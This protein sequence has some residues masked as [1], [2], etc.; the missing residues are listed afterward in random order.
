[1]GEHIFSNRWSFS[2]FHKSCGIILN[3]LFAGN[4][5]VHAGP[6]DWLPRYPYFTPLDKVRMK[7]KVD[8]L[9]FYKRNELIVWKVT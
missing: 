1:M 3:E 7:S 6:V 4:S 5:N 9:K 8:E 2:T